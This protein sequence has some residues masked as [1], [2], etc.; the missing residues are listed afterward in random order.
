[1]NQIL[2]T[3]ILLALTI[4]GGAYLYHQATVAKTADPRLPFRAIY[5]GYYNSTHSIYY[6]AQGCLSGKGPIMVWDPDSQAWAPG[7]KACEGALVLARLDQVVEGLPP[8]EVEVAQN[9]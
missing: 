6:I 3:L 5:V 1:M 4:L 9:G 8:W 2:A 7:S